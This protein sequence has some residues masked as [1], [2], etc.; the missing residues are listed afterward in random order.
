MRHGMH[1]SGRSLTA[2]FVAT[3]LAAIPMSCTEAPQTGAVA[4]D[5]FAARADAVVQSEVVIEGLRV[6]LAALSKSVANLA[7]PDERGREVMEATVTIVDLAPAPTK[8]REPL[9]DLGF[10]RGHWPAAGT[11]AT[12]E[13]ENLSLW[14]EFLALVEFFHHFNFYNIRGE[15]TGEDSSRT[16]AGFKGLA[17]LRSGAIMAVEGKLW[18]EWKGRVERVGDAEETVWRIARFETRSLDFAEG[19]EPLF[20]DVGDL[21]FDNATWRRVVA[22]P[23]DEI[24]TNIVLDI[25]FGSLE[26]DEYLAN[27]RTNQEEGGD[28]VMDTTQTV[29]VDVDR[30]G[31]DDFYVTGAGAESVFFRNN[32]DGTF[33]DITKSLGLDQKNVY[34]AAFGDLDNDG[35]PDAFLSMFNRDGATRYLVNENG[36]FV[37]RTDTLDLVLPNMVIPIAI[38]D[39]NNDGL[40]DVYLSTYVNAYLPAV[41]LANERTKRETGVYR[42]TFPWLDNETAHDVLA[43]NREDGHPVS[44]TYG[45]PNWLLVNRGKGRFERAADAGVEGQFNTLASAWSDFDL[46]GDMDLYAVAEGGPNELFRNN[47]DGTFTEV[48]DEVAGEIGFGM[49]AGLGD[50]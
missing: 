11:P 30:D 23:R 6:P 41:Y 50:Y 36:R 48:T 7:L 2:V 8:A 20:F 21:A 5:G 4:T 44:H 38:S 22:S 34:S 40:L 19:P 26:M 43:R 49:G 3:L 31:F 12:V 37:D 39:Y 16:D 13:K 14:R 29:V 32:G 17:Q 10:E 46:D 9:L 45:P 1:G 15:M 18:L 42:D 24:I 35:D 47:G 25:R 28:G 33:S 27:V